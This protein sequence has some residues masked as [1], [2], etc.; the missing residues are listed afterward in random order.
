MISV[1]DQIQIQKTVSESGMREESFVDILGGVDADEFEQSFASIE[2][3]L[4]EFSDEI[5]ENIDHAINRIKNRFFNKEDITPELVLE[6]M[7]N[8]KS[9]VKQLTFNCSLEV[10]SEQEK[11]LP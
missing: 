8:V 5:M 3:K 4:E 7:D 1:Y 10:E 11:L 9:E 6:M 2:E